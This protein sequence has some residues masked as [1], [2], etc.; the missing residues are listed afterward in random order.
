MT[1]DDA[2][3]LTIL[4]ALAKIKDVKDFRLRE[5]MAE[6]GLN[7]TQPAVF[8]RRL[9]REAR[10]FKSLIG[11]LEQKIDTDAKVIA[12]L[13]ADLSARDEQ[14][15]TLVAKL[16]RLED[17]AHR[18]ADN[19]K[20][21]RDGLEATASQLQE[22]AKNY[23][24]I[25]EFL[26]GQINADTVGALYRLF[27]DMNEQMLYARIEQRPPPNLS[28][29]DAFRQKLRDDLMEALEIPH[30]TLETENKKLKEHNEAL[31]SI[32]KRLYRGG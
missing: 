28:N 3:S 18:K 27:A 9:I 12:Q 14:V 2:E 29:L 23:E 8:Y 13:K 25:K 20:K 22:M 17:E 31:V 6:L 24:L 30:D 26:S 4:N 19:L 32:I 21:E 16:R 10:E 15:K 7:P 1:S 5:F 11:I